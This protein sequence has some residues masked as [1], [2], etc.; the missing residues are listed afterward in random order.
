MKQCVLVYDQWPERMDTRF[1]LKEYYSGLHCGT[2]MDVK[3][4]NRWKPTRIEYD[5]DKQEWYLVDL[6]ADSLIGLIVRLA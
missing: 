2:C 5:W 3:V 1:G 4:G 6:P